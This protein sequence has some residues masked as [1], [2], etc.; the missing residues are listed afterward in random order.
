MS[1]IKLLTINPRNI[2]RFDSNL[3]RPKKTAEIVILD[4]K[5]KWKFTKDAIMSNSSNS[6][7]IGEELVGRIEFTISKNHIYSRT[8]LDF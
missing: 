5:K 3:F 6:P 2:M 8:R 7:F 4:E 1:L